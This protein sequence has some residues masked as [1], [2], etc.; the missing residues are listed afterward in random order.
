M[1]QYFPTHKAKDFPEI[2]RKTT[3]LE[4]MKV[5]DFVRTLGFETGFMQDKSSAKK[6]YVPKFDY[7]EI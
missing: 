4:Y 1:C 2:N 5:V 7:G 6:E 3:T